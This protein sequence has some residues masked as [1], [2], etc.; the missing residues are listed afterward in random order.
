MIKKEKLSFTGHETFAC[1]SYWL[2]KGVDFVQNKGLF[3]ESAV[4]ELGV[5]RNMVSSIRFWLRSFGMTDEQDVLL[6]IAKIIFD[7]AISLST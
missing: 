6:P 5:G 4:V 3:G 2:K 1:R 7:V